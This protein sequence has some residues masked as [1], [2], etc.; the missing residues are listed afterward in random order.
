MARRS[1]GQR[2]NIT[3]ASPFLGLPVRSYMDPLSVIEDTRTWHPLGAAR[4]AQGVFSWDVQ[5]T[6]DPGPRPGGI[7]ARARARVQPN[8]NQWKLGFSVPSNVARCV[9]RKVRREIIHAVGA[10]GKRGRRRYRFSRS[11]RRNLWSNVRC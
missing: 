6:L 10:A 4:P 5:T 8:L 7:R 3:V 1:R 2:D 11:P 9:R